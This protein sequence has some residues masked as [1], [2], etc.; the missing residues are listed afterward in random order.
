MNFLINVQQIENENFYTKE[1][2][3]NKLCEKWLYEISRE[4]RNKISN[5]KHLFF[6]FFSVD[7]PNE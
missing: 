3:K 1:T 6:S 7:Y 4:F 5:Q 2:V